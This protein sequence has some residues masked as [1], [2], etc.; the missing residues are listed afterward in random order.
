LAC[1]FENKINRIEFIIKKKREEK[2]EDGF[3][4]WERPWD[5]F[6]FLLTERLAERPPGL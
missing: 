3:Y 5:G 2:R 6:A 4:P 1:E